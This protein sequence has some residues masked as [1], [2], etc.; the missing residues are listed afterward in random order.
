MAIRFDKLGRAVL[1]EASFGLHHVTEARQPL[2]T[3]D[4]CN[5]GWCF[6]PSKCYL[7]EAWFNAQAE[8]EAVRTLERKLSKRGN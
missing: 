3:T 8:R 5:C 7:R 4:I 2:T 1:L 6:M